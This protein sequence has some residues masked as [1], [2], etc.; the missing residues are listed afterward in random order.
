MI[1][2]GIFDNGTHWS[3]ELLG[4]NLDDSGIYTPHDDYD[5]DEYISNELRSRVLNLLSTMKSLEIQL[6]FR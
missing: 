2:S 3:E 4:V 6:H 5:N 1:L